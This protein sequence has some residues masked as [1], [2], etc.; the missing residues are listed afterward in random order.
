[1]ASGGGVGSPGLSAGGCSD[2]GAAE[3]VDEGRAVV[4]ELVGDPLVV[5]DA[6]AA[7]ES[8]SEEQAVIA[9]PE[10]RTA[11]ARNWMRWSAGRQYFTR[12]AYPRA[13]PMQERRAGDARATGRTAGTAD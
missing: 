9:S 4:A 12:Q 3:V 2:E 6:G 1:V 8:S 10:T 5:D 7:E 11:A 13:R